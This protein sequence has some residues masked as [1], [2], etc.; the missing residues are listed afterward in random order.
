M[1]IVEEMCCILIKFIYCMCVVISL[2]K[3]MTAFRQASVFPLFVVYFKILILALQNVCDFY[4]F[5]QF[6]TVTFCF[7]KEYIK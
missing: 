3:T 7:S 5:N 4:W 1:D 6:F 2:K